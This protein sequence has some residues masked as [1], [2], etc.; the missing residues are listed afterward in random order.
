M[1][2]ILQI[3]K[4]SGDTVDVRLVHPLADKDIKGCL[5]SA[6]NVTLRR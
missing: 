6:G 3:V 2:V 4:I 5:D 1:N